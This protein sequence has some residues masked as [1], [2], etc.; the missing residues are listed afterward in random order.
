VA[1]NL[2]QMPPP[3]ARL[4]P[5][6]V[7]QATSIEQSRAMAEV[8][9]AVL[10]AQSRPRDLQTALAEMRQSC[11]IDKLANRAFFSYKRAGSTVTGPTVYLAR[12]LLRCWGNAQAGLIELSRD[13]IGGQ[14]EM[15]AY[16]WDL[17]TNARVSTTFVVPHARDKDSTVVDLTSLRDVYENNANQGSRRLREMIFSI[18]P[19]W[20]VE[21]AKDICTKTIKDGGG[22]PLPQ[23]ISK[24]ITSFATL[25]VT[26]DDIARRLDKPSQKWTEHDVARL[27][28]VFQSIQR[29]E[30][31]RD[32]EFPPPEAEAVTAAELTGSGRA[33]QQQRRRAEPPPAQS[34]PDPTAEPLSDEPGWP[35]PPA[36]AA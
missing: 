26:E 16:A 3:A 23:R 14:S 6:R 24:M 11:A 33:K 8:Q 15:M 7:G 28:V 5:A 18:L 35:E 29:G 31:D 27:V 22:V 13:P 19:P 17:Q 10:V 36:D 20:F 30:L 34:A 1:D 12:E 25:D 9:A 21:E 4:T 32:E 2:P